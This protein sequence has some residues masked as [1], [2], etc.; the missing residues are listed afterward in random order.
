MSTEQLIGITDLPIN[1]LEE[2]DLAAGIY[3]EGLTT[4]IETCQTPM[5]I[6]LQ[7]D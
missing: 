3:I 1:S 4:F 5:T 7:G 6:A 2:D